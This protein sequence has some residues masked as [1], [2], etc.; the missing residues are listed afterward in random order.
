MRRFWF[1]DGVGR[2]VWEGLEQGADDMY[3]KEGFDGFACMGGWNSCIL[4]GF[5]GLLEGP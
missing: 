4:H 5:D 2:L 1:D 3:G